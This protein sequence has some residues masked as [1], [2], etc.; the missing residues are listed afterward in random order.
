MARLAESNNAH[1][2]NAKRFRFRSA[3]RGRRS[4]EQLRRIDC[5]R[6][7]KV[8]VRPAKEEILKR[9]H[10]NARSG[11]GALTRRSRISNLCEEK[12]PQ[13]SGV[14]SVVAE[15]ALSA[16]RMG[17]PPALLWSSRHGCRY[18]RYPVSSG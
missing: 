2:W 4:R 11:L 16:S 5:R 6:Q 15:P 10:F 9:W 8:L 14:F 12:Q 13:L 17:V 3:I 18:S 7:R 1:T